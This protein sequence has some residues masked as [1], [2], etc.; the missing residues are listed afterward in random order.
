[1]Q[2]A[3]YKEI[4]RLKEMLEKAEIPFYFHDIPEH[5]GHQIV[6]T[7]KRGFNIACSVIQHD[8]SYGGTADLLE[9]SGLLTDAEKKELE[10]ALPNTYIK[11]CYGLMAGNGWRL[12]QNYYDMRDLLGMP[13]NTW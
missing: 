11:Y 10:A 8:F 3:K 1:M 2:K 13:Y 12:L 9:I 7:G 4:F 5:H 6:Y